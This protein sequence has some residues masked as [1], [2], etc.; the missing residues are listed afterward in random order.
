MSDE[1]PIYVAALLLDPHCRKAYL[2]KNWKS[3]LINPAIVGARQI[4]EEKYDIN[5]DRLSNHT[6][7]A[8]RT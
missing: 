1:T 5:I 6:P 2:D 8:I 4:W 3:A 7:Y